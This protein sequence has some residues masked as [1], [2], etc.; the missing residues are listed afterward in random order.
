MHVR[1]GLLFAGLFLIP[2]GGITLLVRAG[3]INASALVDTWRLWPLI[4]VGFG[5]ALLLGRSRAASI[6]TAIAA[7]IL[8]V[9]VGGAVASGNWFSFTECGTTGNA[10]QLVEQSGDFVGSGA[11]EL[12]LRCGNVALTTQPARGWQ[13]TAAYEGTAPTITG[14][15]DRVAV[16]VPDGGDVR[17]QDWTVVIGTQAVNEIDLQTNAATGSLALDGA[18]L[19]TVSVDSN[20]GDVLIDGGSATI[21]RIHVDVNAGR[22][23]V[24][25]AGSATGDLSVNAGAI[26]LCVGADSNLRLEVND[27]LTFVTNLNDRG[28]QQDGTVW[29]RT[30]S[31]DAP[32]IDLTVEG[33]AASFTLDPEEGCK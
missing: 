10:T 27:Q 14:S 3:L 11:V 28:L 9:F 6:G 19:D 24:T 12:D 25:L 1:R 5:I 26:D 2:V 33:N 13:V 22:A 8:G 30:V 20:A 4:L 7:L 31:A 23:R 21:G 15:A 29:T 16:Q 18:T 17:H 32:L